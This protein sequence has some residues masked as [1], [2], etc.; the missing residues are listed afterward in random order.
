MTTK[1]SSKKAPV[2][3]SKKPASK[4]VS[5]K[6]VQAPAAPTP[7]L[8]PVLAAPSYKTLAQATGKS[9][10]ENPTRLMW[11]LCDSMKGKR[12]KDVIAKAIEQ[13]ISYYTARTQYQ[14]WLTAFRN[15]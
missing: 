5:A 8:A 14:S 6:K 9:K 12:R 4:K 11:D 15:S 10:V 13:G 3:D 2:K 7:K 1:T